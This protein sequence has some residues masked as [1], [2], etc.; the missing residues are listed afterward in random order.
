[1]NNKFLLVVL[2]LVGFTWAMSARS[3]TVQFSVA[4]RQQDMTTPEATIELLKQIAASGAKRIILPADWPSIEP[5]SGQLNFA[6]LDLAVNAARAENL[7]VFLM[8]GPSPQWAVT[9]LD[10]IAGPEVVARAHPNLVAYRNYVTNTARYFKGRVAGYQLWQK[11]TLYAMVAKSCVVFD[12][13][14]AGTQAIRL[15]DPTA[16]VIAAEPGDIK[17]AWIAEYLAAVKGRDRADILL[18]SQET[19]IANP[20]QLAWRIQALRNSII[21]K[22][23]APQIWLQCVLDE[24]EEQA[25]ASLVAMS[26]ILKM[27]DI[28]LATRKAPLTA[29]GLQPAQ[30]LMTALAGQ[31]Y[32]G[33][34]TPAPGFCGSQY[35]R[36]GEVCLVLLPLSS[37]S[38]TL[39]HQG[40]A[41]DGPAFTMGPTACFRAL[42][43][44]GDPITIEAPGEVTMRPGYPMVMSGV[45]MPMTLEGHPDYAPVPVA[46]REVTLDFTGEDPDAIHGLRHLPGGYYA[47]YEYR[48]RNMMATIREI[49]PWMHFDVPDGFL[50]YNIEKVPVEVTV[51]VFGAAEANKTGFNLHYDALDGIQFTPWQWIP[52]G[53]DKTYSFTYRLDNALFSG[54]DG[55]DLRVNMGGSID[56][57]RV[58]NLTIK[59]LD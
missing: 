35:S 43:N 25:T 10:E 9:H 31:N 5:Q 51:E 4:L 14:K 17:L 46:A 52:V 49:T 24:A 55:Y 18:L 42:G 45:E 32:G 59:K 33:W 40:E 11:P 16:L 44:A 15:A 47:Q 22:E 41:I 1:M 48:G 8:L 53:T 39:Q 36:D 50:F 6:A 57:V 37:T 56:N 38:L 3:A 23:N 29:Q 20:Q 26:L 34:A 2:L 30:R 7:Q 54:R 58:V 19:L 12:F 13:Y 28:V 21:P 27:T